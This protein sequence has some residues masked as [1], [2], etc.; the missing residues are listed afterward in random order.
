MNM[1]FIGASGYSYDDWRGHFYP[2]DLAKTKYLEYYALYLSAVELNF[3]YYKPPL[4]NTM[5]QMVKRTKGKVHFAVKLHGSMTHERNA[6]PEDYKKFLEAC[7]PLEQAGVL[8]A[9]LAQFP[10]SFHETPA[11]R[12][13]LR[14]LREYMEDRDV[15]AE[16]RNAK[17]LN[18]DALAVLREL[19]LGFCNVDEP[20]LEGLLPPTDIATSDI[21]Y[22]RFHGR[23][24]AQWWQQE[25]PEQRYNYLYTEAE[26]REWVPRIKQLE[27]VTKRTY[28]FTNNHFESK[29]VKNALMLIDLLK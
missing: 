17:W 19:S 23:N 25:K 21:G 13:Y 6:W 28:I 15:V 8:G 22:V 26:L 12:D 14:H 3:T 27:K 24:A 11:N 4:A 5:E 20:Q 7:K 10:F 2:P 1:I 9:Y 16:M 29:A 18:P